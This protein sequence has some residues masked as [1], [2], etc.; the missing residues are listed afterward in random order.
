MQC[1]ERKVV[2]SE[3]FIFLYDPVLELNQGI[4][5]FSLFFT[6]PDF[7]LVTSFLSKRF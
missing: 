7:H 2:H 5:N 1:E 4:D 3:P 6:C